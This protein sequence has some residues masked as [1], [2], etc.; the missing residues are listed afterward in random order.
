MT[1]SSSASDNIF[2]KDLTWFTFPPQNFPRV[3]SVT[4]APS[5]VQNH[6]IG[7]SSTPRRRILSCFSRLRVAFLFSSQ[8]VP[9]IATFATCSFADFQCTAHR[10]S[11]T[12]NIV[13]LLVCCHD[14]FSATCRPR[15]NLLTKMGT[16]LRSTLVHLNPRSPTLRSLHLHP[17][18]QQLLGHP[19][20][21]LICFLLQHSP[22]LR[23]PQLPREYSQC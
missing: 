15:I 10:H 2:W 14:G 1:P 21:V 8:H 4:I 18:L 16:L 17:H 20:Q 9:N 13:G 3:T 5:F 11:I 7:S 22:A 23:P 12:S 19:P 6:G